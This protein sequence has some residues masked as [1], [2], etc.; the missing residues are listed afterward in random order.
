M[1]KT[2]ST[3]NWVQSRVTEEDLSNHVA[4]GALAKKRSFTGG[5][6]VQKI[7]LNQ[8]T[9]KWL[10]SLITWVGDSAHPAQSFSVMYFIFSNFTLKI[11]PNSVSNICNFQVFCEAYRQEEPTVDLFREFYY[12]NRQTEFVDG[13][14]TE[15][16]GV[17]IQK[18]KDVSSPYDKPPSHPKDWNQTW[19]YCQDT[20]YKKRHI[21]TFWAEQ[22]FFCHTHDTSMTIILTK[23]GIIIDVVGVGVKTGRSRVGGP[24]LC[25]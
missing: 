13:P 25:V 9:E 20:H 21:L 10:F 4:T 15:L 22:I 16:G 23:P 14:N 11:G 1:A 18:R 19:F 17:S 3:C 12:I 7:L 2:Y 6:L 24:E 8:R 5:S